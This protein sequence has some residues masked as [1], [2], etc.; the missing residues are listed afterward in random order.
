MDTRLSMIRLLAAN[1]LQSLVDHPTLGLASLLGQS[2]H[3]LHSIPVVIGSQGMATWLQRCIA[4][5]LGICSQ[6]DFVFPNAYV[7]KYLAT[8]MR[9]RWPAAEIPWRIMHW[10]ARPASGPTT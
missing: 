3:P 7:D 6:I 1:H 2:A 8:D 4:Q 9:Q 5:T 10:L